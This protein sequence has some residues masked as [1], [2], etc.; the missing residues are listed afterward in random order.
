MDECREHHSIRISDMAALGIQSKSV[1]LVWGSFLLIEKKRATHP[2][3]HTWS[4]ARSFARSLARPSVRCRHVRQQREQPRPDPLVAAVLHGTY[5]LAV[6]L[7]LV[8]ERL[9]VVKSPHLHNQPHDVWTF[10]PSLC[11]SKAHACV[12]MC[13][14][15]CARSRRSSRTA[16]C[17]VRPPAVFFLLLPFVWCVGLSLVSQCALGVW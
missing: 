7:S 6:S 10:P 5:A 4:I 12:A 15:Y 8:A 17:L 11:P 2:H 3:K 1:S 9:E 16:A 13:T 14:S